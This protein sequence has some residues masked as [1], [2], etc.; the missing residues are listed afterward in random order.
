M[1][2]LVSRLIGKVQSTHGAVPLAR[3]GVRQIQWEF[4]A[5][6][7]GEEDY[8]TYMFLSSEA[9]EELKFWENLPRGL[10]LPI[11]VRVS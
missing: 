2:Q 8:D 4:L 11:I 9:L 1:C 6:C 3:A 5:S 10:Y 7:R